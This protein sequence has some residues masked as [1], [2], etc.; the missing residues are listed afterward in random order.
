MPLRRPFRLFRLVCHLVHG[1]WLAV[2]RMP[3]DPPPR[4]P[5]QWQLV[6]WWHG[7]ALELAGVRVHIRGEP[8][9]GAVLFVANHVS[10]LDISAL[11]TVIDA[12]F[13]GKRELRDWPLL[14]LIIRRGGTIFIERGGRGAAAA[15]A[16]AM[17]ERLARGERVAVFPEGTTTRGTQVRRFHPRL[18]EA[19]IRTGVPIQ[20]VAL[21]YD[22]ACAPFVDDEPFLRHVWRL[23]GQPAVNVEVT[24]LDPVDPAGLGRRQLAEMTRAAIRTRVETG[25]EAV[26]ADAAATRLVTPS[27]G[28]RQRR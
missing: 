14:G 4:T 9:D 17:I 7:R 24:L 11:L 25:V 12:G 13:I 28:D 27:G 10:W 21:R 5:G 1:I 20:P 23:L 18:F 6:R 22:N 8:A 16:A 19:A 26:P 3:A 15:A 2:T